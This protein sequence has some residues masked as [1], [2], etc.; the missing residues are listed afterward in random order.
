[1]ADDSQSRNVNL[2]LG[3][4]ATS[5]LG[6]VWGKVVTILAAISLIMGIALE[7]QSFVTGYYVL[8]KTSAET[9]L[10]LEQV[11]PSLG[12]GSADEFR[13]A[14]E[15]VAA[16]CAVKLGVEWHPE[17]RPTPLPPPALPGADATEE[18]KVQYLA[19]LKK[20]CN[21][22]DNGVLV[23]SNQ[24]VCGTP[25]RALSEEEKRAL[26]CSTKEGRELLGGKYGCPL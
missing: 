22:T 24:A 2:N 12:Y 7:V 26:A 17:S 14:Y 25:P 1:V 21:I 3:S 10:V 20:Y 15:K 23:H 5:F 19:E 8:H 11:W 9:C 13:K 16:D 6:T 4:A 18:M